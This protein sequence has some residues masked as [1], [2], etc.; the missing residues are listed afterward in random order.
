M[1]KYDSELVGGRM[2][3][4]GYES[5]DVPEDADVI[6]INTCSVRGGA[7][8]R[9]YGRLGELKR[10]KKRRPG[11]VVA[12]LGCQAQ[13]EGADLLNRAPHIDLIVGTREF[14]KL[15]ELVARVRAGERPIIA[16][17]ESTEVMVERVARVERAPSAFIA[18]MRGCD[19]N[20]TFCIV[21]TTRGRVQSRTVEDI[22]EEARWLVADGVREIVLLGQTV[23][24]YGFDLATPSEAEALGYRRVLADGG[25]AVPE[26]PVSLNLT[27]SGESERAAAP[28]TLELYQP[29]PEKPAIPRL[30]ELIRK[31]GAL[32]GLD[33]IRLV[34]NHIAYLDDALI[35]ALAEMPSAMPFLPIPAQSGSDRVL[36]E[37]RRG[38]TTD[39]YRRRI[40]KLRKRI[41]NI[42]LSS[43]WIVGFPG[44]TDAEFQQSC[45]FLREMK[46]AQNFIFRYSPRPETAAFDRAELPDEVVAARNTELLK[47]AEDVQRA[48]WAR[49]VGTVRPVLVELA[50]KDPGRVGGRTPENLEVHFAG[51]ADLLG[52]IVNVRITQASA[53]SGRGE[54]AGQC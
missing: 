2:R 32:P 5:T 12:I 6:A 48:C 54:L 37:M 41:P 42:E 18:V 4:K 39:I 36:R 47:I 33:R 11:L 1:N 24:S 45:D 10:L 46:F 21:P 43:D 17:D 15:P 7:E 25:S 50:G 29:A 53:H 27:K 28:A 20:C 3:A 34:T 23:N 44:E 35:A 22:L 26:Y 51:D 52:E 9:V 14:T 31:L 13:R 38:Y 30:A 8:D 16:V 49:H 40:D 19:L